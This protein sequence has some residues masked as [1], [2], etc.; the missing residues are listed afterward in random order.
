MSIR[1]PGRSPHIAALAATT[2]VALTLGFSAGAQAA[3]QTRTFAYTGGE[4]TFTVPAGVHLLHVVAVGGEGAA[5]NVGVPGGIGGSVTADVPVIPGEALYLV[6]GGSGGS[7]GFNGGGRGESGGGTGGAASD[8]RTDPFTAPGSLS[9]RLI[10]AAGGGGG[11]SEGGGRG[12]AA[13]SPGEK[14]SFTG[15]SGAAPAPRWQVAPAAPAIT[16]AV[17]GQRAA[18]GQEAAVVRPSPEEEAAAG[19][20]TAA[21]AAAAGAPTRPN[22]AARQAPAVVVVRTSSFPAPLRCLPRLR[23]A[24]RRSR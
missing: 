16:G 14:L 23:R 6:V 17:L 10:V 9:S 7:G 11:G 2:A 19:A 13:G 24:F 3:T 22:L 8:V 20:T 15:S 1:I 4:Q 18:S 21:G 12:G 5:G